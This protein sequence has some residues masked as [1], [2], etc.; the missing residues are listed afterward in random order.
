MAG[1]SIV[2][3]ETVSG[4]ASYYFAT[5]DF[6]TALEVFLSTYKLRSWSEGGV[7]L[8]S[9]VLARL[10]TATGTVGLDADDVDLRLIVRALSRAIGKTILFDTL[11]K[12]TLTVHA[13]CRRPGRGARDPHA[14]VPRLRV[15]T[16]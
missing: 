5:T 9:R 13:A 14:A 8:V 2:P 16:G 10:D 1:R 4:N 15:E 7:T 3:D 12:E 6:E 11:P